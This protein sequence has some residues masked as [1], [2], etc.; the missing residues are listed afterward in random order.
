LIAG[1]P[2]I[3]TCA[4]PIPDGTK[5][6]LPLKCEVYTVKDGES[7]RLIGAMNLKYVHSIIQFNPSLDRRCSN[8]QVN[9]RTLG[10]IICLTAPGGV[11]LPGT[12]SNTSTQAPHTG[13]GRPT[14]D[15]TAPVPSNA[16]SG[17]ATGTSKES[18]GAWVVASA[19]DTC[20]DICRQ[21]GIT[22]GVLRSLN[23]S[24]PQDTD[25]TASLQTSAAYCVARYSPAPVVDDQKYYL[26]DNGC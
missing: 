21:G 10:S 7:C 16:T 1:N 6:C 23:P 14:L 4:E 20:A 19:N 2:R 5:L 26:R 3:S 24:I 12:P 8:L 18:C 15:E 17:A 22:V 9:R 25:C 13:T 11:F